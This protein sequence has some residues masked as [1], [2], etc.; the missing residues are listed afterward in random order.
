[1]DGSGAGLAHK[2]AE[3]VR[4]EFSGGV[5]APR[6]HPVRAHGA[7]AEVS[8]SGRTIGGQLFEGSDEVDL[9]LSGEALRDLLNQLAAEGCCRGRSPAVRGG[10]WRYTAG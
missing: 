4:R 5:S 8:L 7:L 1:M 9:F 6:T 10:T 2:P 3:H